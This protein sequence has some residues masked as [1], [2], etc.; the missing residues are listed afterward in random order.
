VSQSEAEKSEAEK[1]AYYA[2]AAS[3]N[4]KLKSLQKSETIVEEQRK[5]EISVELYGVEILKRW[6]DDKEK[7]FYVL[8]RM[9]KQ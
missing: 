6:R 8:A 3:K 9:P 1:Q 2:L 7:V 5:E 4:A